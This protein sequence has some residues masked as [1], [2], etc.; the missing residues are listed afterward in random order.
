MTPNTHR[1]S[2]I[3]AGAGLGLALVL[4]W[5]GNAAAQFPQDNGPGDGPAIGGPPPIG[6]PPGELNP[7]P[8]RPPVRKPAAPRPAPISQPPAAQLPVAQPSNKPLT[9]EERSAVEK[10]GGASR[11][12]FD[13]F[14][15]T[16]TAKTEAE[17]VAIIALLDRAMTDEAALGEKNMDYARQLKGWACN[18][19]GEALVARGKNS[20]ALIQ[21]EQAVELNPEHWKARQNRGVSYA[22]LGKL[23]EALSD[24]SR[25]I[26]LNPGYANAWFNRGELYYQQG[27]LAAAQKDY[28]EAIRRSPEEPAFYQVRGNVRH[29]LKEF[30]DA[31][32]DYNRSIELDDKNAIS[33]I[34]R[35]DTET[36]MGQYEQAATDYRKAIQLNDQLG[37]AYQSTAWLMST[38]PDDRFR[39]PPKAILAAHKAIDLDGRKRYEYFETLAA[40]LAANGQYDEAVRTQ[41]QAI[42]LAPDSRGCLGQRPRNEALM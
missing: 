15:K 10:P 17:Y 39:D 6:R 42:Q 20:V 25:V 1:R 30:D 36:T 8:L 2:S 5:H 14:Q 9:P 40:A 7:R 37:R 18:K 19:R 11:L 38:C 4:A 12:V 29:Q 32:N 28:T 13:A 33:Y 24:F 23:K 34:Y 35:G 27:D 21:F 31:M 16:Q 26:A 22:E 41:Q 3:C